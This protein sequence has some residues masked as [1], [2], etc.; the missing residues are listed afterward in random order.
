ML[1]FNILGLFHN[2]I[3][4]TYEKLAFMLPLQCILYSIYHHLLHKDIGMLDRKF[5]RN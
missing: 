3:L 1:I 5:K 2:F 4:Q